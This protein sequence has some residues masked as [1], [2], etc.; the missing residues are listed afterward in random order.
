MGNYINKWWKIFHPF[1]FLDHLEIL[2]FVVDKE[3]KIAKTPEWVVVMNLC[4]ITCN[5]SFHTHTLAD[6]KTKKQNKSLNY[7]FSCF[8]CQS[9]IKYSKCFKHPLYFYHICVLPSTWSV[10]QV[11]WAPEVHTSIEKNCFAWDRNKECDWLLVN[12]SYDISSN[13]V[14]QRK[15]PTWLPSIY[16]A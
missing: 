1:F 3:T 12:Q 7:R 10:S 5:I 4:K 13:L 14:V 15:N 8:L 16:N 6:N 11:R 9:L 2:G